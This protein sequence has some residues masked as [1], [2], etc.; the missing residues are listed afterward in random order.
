V[1]QKAQRARRSKKWWDVA[2]LFGCVVGALSETTSAS[3]L[4]DAA[5][6]LQPGQ[7]VRLATTLPG[8]VLAPDDGADFLQWGSS[9]V[10]DPVRKE[11]RFVGKR[12]SVYPY[13]FLV[14]SEATNGWSSDRAL[15]PDLASA[16]NGHAYDHNTVD[17]VTGTH[18]FRRYNSR[19]IYVWAGSWS[20]LTLPADY[21][22]IAASISW[23]GSLAEA[24]KS[25]S[26]LV[27]SDNS[28]LLRFNG[29]GW[30]GLGTSPMTSYHTVS[31]FN[32]A[33]NTLLIGGG[34]GSSAM[35]KLNAATKAIAPIATPP[36]NLGSSSSQG[37]LVSDPTTDQLIGYQKG[38]GAWVQYDVS[39]DRWTPLTQSSGSGS[40]PQ[41]GTPN[42]SSAQGSVVAAP[43]ST[44]GV[45]M[46]VQYLGSGNAGVWLYKHVEPIVP[47]PPGTVS[48]R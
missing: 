29:T 3:P 24:G 8:S 42:L 2:L 1:D 34:N 28:N 31:E 12:H 4:S 45:V 13:R 18:Y 6:S 46:F 35:W 38:V 21:V 9:A 40:T 32:S 7:S 22:E 17:P 37:V 19:N 27:Y 10:W 15:H 36:F 11:F 14:Y 47:I 39:T 30:A 33:S 20:V 25:D 26:G 5:N 43:I 41:E 16:Q 23:V 44:L 48:A